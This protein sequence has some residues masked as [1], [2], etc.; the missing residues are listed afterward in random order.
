MEALEQRGQPYL[1]KLPL[2]PRVKE[3]VQRLAWQGGWRADGQVWEIAEAELQLQGWTRARRALVV[4]RKPGRQRPR[5]ALARQQPLLPSKEQ[6]PVLLATARGGATTGQVLASVSQASLQAALAPVLASDAVL[7]S[8]GGRAYPG[9]ARRRGIQHEAVNVSAGIRVRGSYRIQ[10]VNNRHQQWKAFLGPF[11]GVVA[12]KYLDSYPRWFQQVELVR[13][14]SP[15]S[16]LV[17]SMAPKC[18]RFAN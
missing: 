3:L 6:V 7:L 8:D 5:K 10:T 1:F 17:A 14:A 16:C 18:I 15:G 2:Q 11:R 9:C 4:R 12:T 13:E